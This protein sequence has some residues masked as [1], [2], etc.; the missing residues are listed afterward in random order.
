M[1]TV[2]KE[3]TGKSASEQSSEL[4]RWKNVNKGKD[5]YIKKN[6]NKRYIVRG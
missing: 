4:Q 3:V 5:V 6:G 2:L 1:A